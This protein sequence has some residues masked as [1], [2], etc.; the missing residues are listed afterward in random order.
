MKQKHSTFFNR[1]SSGLRSRT[2]AKAFS[3][4][5]CCLPLFALILLFA[6][7]IILMVPEGAVFGSHTDWLSQHVTLAETIR[8]ACLEQHTLLPDWLELGGGASASGFNPRCRRRGDGPLLLRL[9]ETAGRGSGGVARGDEVIQPLGGVGPPRG[10]VFGERR[11]ADGRVVPQKAIAPAG[12]H[13]GHARLGVAVRKLQRAALDVQ[14]VL[15][16]LPHAKEL[17][18]GMGLKA[19]RQAVVAAGQPLEL[20]ALDF[21]RGA[22]LALQVAAVARELL[23]QQLSL[24]VEEYQLAA[25]RDLGADAA[26][27]DAGGVAVDDDLRLAVGPVQQRPVAPLQRAAILHGAHAQGAL[28]PRLHAKGLSA[29]AAN[30]P[31]LLI[32][33]EHTDHPFTAPL[34]RPL[35]MYFCM[36]RKMSATGMIVTTAKAVR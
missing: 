12:H 20:A 9:P 32:Y 36:K 22:V 25:P 21:Q 24:L 11:L 27:C 16:V 26:V 18:V 28:A 14:A 17:F 35:M 7:L 10:H 6:A 19:G 1:L 3:R 34:V 8:N 2:E 23:Q 33:M 4:I 15:L 5:K 30:Q 13:K 29:E 31:S